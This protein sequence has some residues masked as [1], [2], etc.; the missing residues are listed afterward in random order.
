M[1]FKLFI[2]VFW[3]GLKAL[4]L[5]SVCVCVY[6]FGVLCGLF[7]FFLFFNFLGVKIPA[8]IIF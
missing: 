6:V 3:A 5:S 8:K 1:E 7:F 2:L 4:C